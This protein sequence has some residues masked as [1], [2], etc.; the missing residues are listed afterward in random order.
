VLSY[1]GVRAV[2]HSHGARIPPSLPLCP[3]GSK[4]S[5]IRCRQMPGWLV[6]SGDRM[7]PKTP[8]AVAATQNDTSLPC[9]RASLQRLGRCYKLDIE[10][11]CS[12]LCNPEQVAAIRV[13]P[14]QDAVAGADLQLC[15]MPQRAVA[16]RSKRT[17]PTPDVGRPRL[18]HQRLFLPLNPQGSMQFSQNQVL[19]PASFSVKTI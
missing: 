13:L 17:D 16:L 9:H 10:V 14:R 5:R 4:P 8:A 2:R 19:H 7:L 3:P 15:G 11:P 12:V 1:A 6:Q 18:Q